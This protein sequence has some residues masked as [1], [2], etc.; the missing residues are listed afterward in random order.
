MLANPFESGSNPY[1]D[2]R[3]W[4]LVNDNSCL[5]EKKRL[6][7]SLTAAGPPVESIAVHRLGK[8]GGFYVLFFSSLATAW[9]F[10]NPVL[11]EI[12]YGIYPGTGASFCPFSI[13]I[14]FF[15]L[16]SVEFVFLIEVTTGN[17]TV[18]KEKE[19]RYLFSSLYGS[20]PILTLLSLLGNLNIQYPFSLI[21]RYTREHKFTKAC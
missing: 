9:L 7:M 2:P 16:F 8:Y 6:N 15:P 18:S 21:L 3:H 4:L 1:Y 20:I 10:P 19:Y 12:Q 13:N 17:Q 11:S 14:F 5:R